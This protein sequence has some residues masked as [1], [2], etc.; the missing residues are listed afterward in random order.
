[1]NCQPPQLVD[2]FGREISYA[3]LSVT[4]RCDFRC[5]YCMA[6]EMKFLPRSQVL[7]LE[8]LFEVGQALVELGVRKLRLTGANPWCA[9]RSCAW[10]SVWDVC[11]AWRN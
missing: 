1:M 4:D 2:R 6:E 5:V 3:R 9:T 7:S 10:S 8:E 11:R